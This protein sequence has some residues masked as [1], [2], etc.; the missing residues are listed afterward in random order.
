MRAG[1]EDVITT[2]T[3]SSQSPFASYTFTYSSAL[4]GIPYLAYGIQKYRGTLPIKEVFASTRRRWLP[5]P[6]TVRNQEKRSHCHYLQGGDPD[7]RGDQSAHP[8]S[9][10]SSSGSDFPPP[11]QLLR[12]HPHRPGWPQRHSTPPLIKVNITTKNTGSVT[13]YTNTINYTNQ[14]MGSAFTQ[15][16]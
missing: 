14:A 12:Q 1:Q 8:I 13:Y 3:G 7:I 11:P 16:T 5:G 4:P 2:F 10:L 15:F 6:R 9:G